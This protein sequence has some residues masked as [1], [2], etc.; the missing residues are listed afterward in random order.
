[1]KKLL[2]ISILTLLLTGCT[3]CKLGYSFTGGSTGAAKT[4]S[5]TTFTNTA[6]IIQPTLAQAFT[7]S[8]RD[9][10][11]GQT[12]LSLVPTNGDLHFEGYISSYNVAPVAVTGNQT[13]ALNRLT[14]TV[15]VKFENKLDDTKNFEQSF[16]RFADWQSSVPLNAVEADLI[17]DINSQLVQDIFN[18]AVINW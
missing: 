3:G 2:Y 15:M 14:I 9:L 18:K 7:E 1:M 16:S 5:V 17:K 10:F 13:A 6:T 4:V 8:L 12:R 11:V